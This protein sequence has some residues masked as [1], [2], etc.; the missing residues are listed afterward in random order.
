MVGTVTWRYLF[1]MSERQKNVCSSKQMR[2]NTVS[3]AGIWK[4]S[5]TD[6]G[7]SGLG[8]FECFPEVQ[9]GRNH[10]GQNVWTHANGLWEQEQSQD[11]R[12]GPEPTR[13]RT[14]RSCT[15]VRQKT[16]CSLCRAATGGRLN[17][18]PIMTHGL[19]RRTECGKNSLDPSSRSF[20]LSFRLFSLQPLSMQFLSIYRLNLLMFLSNS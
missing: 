4:P 11:M 1:H 9:S 8:V 6:R 10:N 5:V 2:F 20:K 3:C 17:F 12:K 18:V 19:K 15:F 13:Y 14:A 7:R 16:A